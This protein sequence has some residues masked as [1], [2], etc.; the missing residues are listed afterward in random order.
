MKIGLSAKTG[1][2]TGSAGGSGAFSGAGAVLQGAAQA[3]LQAPQAVG[4][5]AAAA[6]QQFE[7]GQQVL[8]PL[9]QAS[10]EAQ[11]LPQPE[12]Q[13]P[14]GAAQLPQPA[15]LRTKPSFLD[16]QEL[17]T[18]TDEVWVL[19]DGQWFKAAESMMPNI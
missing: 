18:S 14:Q 13:A 5:Q 1:P 3:E 9:P 11:A 8:Q 2:T 4:Q 17:V 15:P 12:P 19:E 10:Q 16:G 7:V 6:L